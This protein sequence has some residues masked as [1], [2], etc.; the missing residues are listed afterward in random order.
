MQ[1]AFCSRPRRWGAVRMPVAS[2]AILPIVS[3]AAVL[4]VAMPLAGCVPADDV[5]ADARAGYVDAAAATGADFAHAGK[6][7]VTVTEYAFDPP[8]LAFR[9]GRPYVLRLENK[10]DKTHFF[11]AEPFF[12]SVAV[13]DLTGRGDTAGR[14]LK[15]IG[16]KPGET[17][18]LAFVPL[19]KGSYE[20][21]CTAPFHAAFGMRG[22]ITVD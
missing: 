10:G 12:K 6:L 1:H 2:P 15:T 20:F 11:S 17:R 13:R 3:V 19:R 7:T 9:T 5:F 22:T 21:L 4:A 18:E 8:A 16:L 14:Y